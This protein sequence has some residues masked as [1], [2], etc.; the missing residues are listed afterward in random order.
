MGRL[1]N[2]SGGHTW[3]GGVQYAP[4]RAIGLTTRNLD[5]GEALWGF[6]QQFAV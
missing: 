2:V 4:P 1:A 3:P 5:A 6:C